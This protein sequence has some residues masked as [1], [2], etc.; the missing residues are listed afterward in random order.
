MMTLTGRPL[1]W[2][3]L[4][5]LGLLSQAGLAAVEATVDRD[6][7]ALG[8]TLQ[9]VISAT[10]DDE[11]L[12]IGS[13]GGCN[14]HI[15]WEAPLEDAADWVACELSLADLRGGHSGVEINSGRANAIRLMAS[16]IRS[17]ACRS[18]LRVASWTGG[19]RRNAIPRSCRATILVE[20]DQVAPVRES[21]AG[22]CKLFSNS[23]TLLY[24]VRA[25]FIPLRYGSSRIFRSW[26][27]GAG[28]FISGKIE[29]FMAPPDS[30]QSH[31]H[32][33]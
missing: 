17:A 9:L 10:E 15:R 14:V 11:E 12:T 28:Q 4:L 7:I 30:I 6:Q 5:L 24:S 21:L 3:L 20:A 16:A 32:A 22:S 13:A 27:P 29:N 1:Q 23:K 31:L 19:D 25:V 8:D 26:S 2:G 18:P 33:P